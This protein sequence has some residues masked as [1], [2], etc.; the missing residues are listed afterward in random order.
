MQ[1][2]SHGTFEAHGKQGRRRQRPGEEVQRKLEGRTNVGYCQ[3]LC[4]IQS[5]STDNHH[6]AFIC[7]IYR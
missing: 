1:K 5:N 2:K 3:F 4:V 7:L 6:R